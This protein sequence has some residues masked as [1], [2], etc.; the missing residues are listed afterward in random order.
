[1]NTPQWPSNNPGV[2][3]PKESRYEAPAVLELG[4]AEALTLGTAGGGRDACNCS[5]AKGI[6]LL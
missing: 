2:S 4:K 5:K 1:M 3:N 6:R